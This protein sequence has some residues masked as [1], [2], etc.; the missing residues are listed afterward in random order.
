MERK[1]KITLIEVDYHPE[2]LMNLAHVFS[3]SDFMV[4]IFCSNKIFNKISDQYKKL[5]KIHHP[6]NDESLK[7]FFSRSVDNLNESDFIFYSTLANNFKFFSELKI[8]SKQILLIHNANI[9][10][11][12]LKSTGFLINLQSLIT[13]SYYFIFYT[14]GRFDFIYRYRFLKKIDHICLPAE[15]IYDY[16]SKFTKSAVK[17]KL[18]PPIPLVFPAS[19]PESKEIKREKIF[20]TIIGR[21]EK[22]RKNYKDVLEAFK[23]AAT[24]FNNEVELTLL[25]SPVNKSGKRILSQFHSIQN[26]RFKIKSYDGYVDQEEF[27]KVINRTDFLIVPVVGKTQFRDHIE[28]YGKTKITGNINDIILHQIPAIIPSS[29]SLSPPL[30]QIAT[31]YSSAYE[32]STLITK[33]VNNKE[34]VPL[35]KHMPEVMKYYSFQNTQQK[36]KSIF[37]S[38][39][40]KQDD[41]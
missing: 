14:I 34:F 12:N 24:Q 36:V 30:N 18:L 27:N 13:F 16:I 29:Y 1:I 15:E 2:V 35:N 22:T 38:L 26:E 21:V 5:Y 39:I 25:G 33:W 37:G 19:K 9:F 17:T 11:N 6:Q 31:Q 28:I 23:T 32:L 10:L 4:Q 41:E 7:A 8:T 3:K 20:I 40:Q